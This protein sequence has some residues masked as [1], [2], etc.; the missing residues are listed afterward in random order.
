MRERRTL[1]VGLVCGYCE[2]LMSLGEG[3]LKKEREGG[4]ECV[5][6]IMVRYT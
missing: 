3:G 2:L 5:W 4:R 1:G 6:K